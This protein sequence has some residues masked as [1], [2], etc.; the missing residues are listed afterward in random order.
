MPYIDSKIRTII[1]PYLSCCWSMWD[2][3]HLAKRVLGPCKRYH[4]YARV[5]G[6]LTAAALELGRRLD[7]PTDFDPNQD[8]LVRPPRE[9]VQVRA[10]ADFILANLTDPYDG[11][12]NYCI[13]V[14]LG[15]D[16]VAMQ[17]LVDAFYKYDIG[18]YEDMAIKKNGD[19]P[20]YEVHSAALRK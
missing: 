14:M 15:G 16:R 8:W 18:P 4:H 9:G 10:L 19:I 13:T 3:Y 7:K 12:V 6:T 5:L 20:Y 1:D 2:C 17:M 11:I